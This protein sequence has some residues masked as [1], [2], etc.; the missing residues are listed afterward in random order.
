MDTQHCDMF[1]N[2]LFVGDT[3]AQPSMSGRSPYI[4]IKTIDSFTDKGKIRVT[5]GKTKSVINYPERL[6]KLDSSFKISTDFPYR[7]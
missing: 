3:V 5:D 4:Q 2:K 1:N 6:L 7:H